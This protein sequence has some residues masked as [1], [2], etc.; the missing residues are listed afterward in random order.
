MKMFTNRRYNTKNAQLIFTA[1]NT[2]L[3]DTD[4]LRISEIGFVNKTKKKWNDLTA[5]GKF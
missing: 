4:V 1:H 2:D 3:L 5:A